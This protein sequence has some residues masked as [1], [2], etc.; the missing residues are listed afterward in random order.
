MLRYSST[1]RATNVNRSGNKANGPKPNDP[2]PKT[3]ITKGLEAR[4]FRR[5]TV[6]NIIS[7]I[8]NSDR[9]FVYMLTYVSNRKIK[10]VTLIVETTAF[11]M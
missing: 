7:P 10:S 3:Q 8:V 4:A 5:K 6:E 1:A 2:K 9:V 11:A